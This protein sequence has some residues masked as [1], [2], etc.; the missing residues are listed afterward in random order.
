M[1]GLHNT[2]IHW[3][4]PKQARGFKLFFNK[5]LLGHSPFQISNNY[6]LFFIVLR[7]NFS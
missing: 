4:I 5:K 7:I 3:I 1:E 2:I 6:Y